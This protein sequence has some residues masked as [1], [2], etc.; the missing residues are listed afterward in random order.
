M[1]IVYSG[2]PYPD[3]VTKSIFLAG[4][5]PR[6]NKIT[7]RNKQIWE[8][9]KLYLQTGFLVWGKVPSW[10]PEALRILK[11]S[12]YDGHVFVPE[13][14]PGSKENTDYEYHSMIE[15]ETEGLNR[16][17]IIL[18]WV[19]RNLKTMPAFT[20]NIEWGAWRSSGKVIFGAPAESPKNRYLELEASQ[21]NIPIFRTLKETIFHAVTDLNDGAERTGGE[22]HIPLF[23]WK[24]DSFQS[25]YNSQKSADN[26]LDKARILWT[27]KT[28]PNKSF[29]F[30]WII[31]VDIFVAAEN[32]H[33][34]NEF[35]I[36]HSDISTVMLWQ[37]DFYNILNS[38]I[39]L[40]K[41]FR[42]PART[43]DGFIYELPGG[44]AFKKGVS[45]REL[46]AEEVH[47]ETGL[48]FEP[49]RFMPHDSRQ[50]AGTWSTHHAHLFSINL[51]K[52]E[53]DWYKKCSQ[54][55]KPLGNENDSERTYIYVKTL[56]EILAE[57]LTDWSTLGMIL[58]VISEEN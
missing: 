12:G 56:K 9:L 18:F 23:I 49:S 33:K 5:T 43:N 40:I 50:L 2:E 58:Q 21:H 3:K 54:T 16:A 4:P 11:E 42:S 13:D 41:E 37:K 30:S 22:C 38:E 8:Y 1:Q 36:S 25:W 51:T 45:P 34:T 26:R 44:S 35:V 10:R 17:D 19:P 39:V 14:R 55:A 29:T 32:R 27:Y 48:Y 52:R 7:S 28:G 6:N 47:E 15:W 53:L 24:T 57:K 31:W 20:T 46:A